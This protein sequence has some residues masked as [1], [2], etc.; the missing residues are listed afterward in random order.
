MLV[1]TKVSENEAQL[2]TDLDGDGR[3]EWVVN[4]WNPKNPL[5]VWRLVEVKETDP[6]PAGNAKFKMEPATLAESGNSHGMGVGDLNGDHRLDVLTGSGW[7]EHPAENPWGQ[8][9][10]FHADWQI[11]ASIP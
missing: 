6:K 4:S 10:K 7:Y 5:K 3:P 8:T 1:D 11:Q 9:W 2:F